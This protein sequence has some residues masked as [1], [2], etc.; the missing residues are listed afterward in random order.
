MPNIQKIPKLVADDGWLAPQTDQI[1]E[2]INLFENELSSIRKQYD[3]LFD[4]ADTHLRTGIHYQED[5]ALWLVREW[6]PNAKSIQIIGEF[7]QWSGENHQLVNIGHGLWE[8][9]LTGSALKHRD[10]VKLRIQGADDSI[11]DRI[12]ACIFRAVQNPETHDFTGQVW[13][14]APE[15]VYQWTHPDF[16]AS[17]ITSPLIYEAHTGMSGE[18]PRLHTY[19]EF[20]DEVIPHIVD[21]GYNVIQLMAVQEHPYYGSFGYHVSNF[22]AACSRFGTPEDLKYLIDTA[23]GNGLA[24]L[25]DIVHSHAVKNISEGLNYFDGTDHQY[26]HSGSKG[27]HPQWDSKCFDYAKPEVRK[28][29]LSNTR[30]W[31][32]EFK[33]DGYR[34]DGVTSMLYEHHGNISFDN[35]A[36]YFDAGVDK[37][38]VLYLQLATTLCR[39]INPHALI[40]AEDMSGMPGLCRPVEEGGVGFTHRLSMGIPDFW[41]KLLKETRDEEWNVHEIWD[42]MVNRRY[43]EKNICYAESHDQALVGDKTLAFRLMD[44][45]MYWHMGKDDNDAVIDR[46]MALHKIIRLLTFSLAGEGWL[47]FMGNEFGHPEWLDFPREGNDWSYHYC[48]RQW[49]LMHDP[50]LKYQYLA[51]FDKDLVLLG[52]KYHLLNSVH[53]Q[54]VWAHDEDK[55]LAY[56]RGGLI[57]VTN[58]HHSHSHTDYRLPVP[59]T[60]SGK[61]KV[62]L[63]TDLPDYGGHDRV[64]MDTEHF[65]EVSYEQDALHLYLPARTALV[66]EKGC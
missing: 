48:R 18:E 51:K 50:N 26:F 6:A 22:F 55:I 47:N 28:F 29:L 24:V 49:S 40:I 53:A 16:D 37:D 32:E 25:L 41:I 20:A 60:G 8:I 59:Q 57:F 66:L 9:S 56:E 65:T 5:S 2:R 39:E 38:A 21:A 30:Y 45:N 58:L 4:Y 42:T 27:D 14:P 34:F 54:Q 23:H 31:L 11:R 15:D 46:G 43:G 12:P 19:R 63:N 13:Q 62:I 44:Q 7:N 35:L 52:R 10:Q 64:S 33:F 3:S 1:N 17:S 61:Y 36:K